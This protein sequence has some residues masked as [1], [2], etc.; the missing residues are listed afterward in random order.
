[1]DFSILS[2]HSLKMKESENMNKFLD[3][4][5]EQKKKTTTV[6]HEA[7]SDTNSNWCTWIGPQKFGKETRGIENLSKNQ[8]H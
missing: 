8:D 2:D 7:D 6:E 4:T 5:K 3:H 1:M